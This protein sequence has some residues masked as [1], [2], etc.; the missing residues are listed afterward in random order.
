MCVLTFTLQPAGQPNPLPTQGST[1]PHS[2]TFLHRDESHGPV[3][4]FCSNCCTLL[5][6]TNPHHTHA[7][8]HRHTHT[9]AVKL[10]VTLGTSV[11]SVQCLSSSKQPICTRSSFLIQAQIVLTLNVEKVVALHEPWM[12]TATSL[13][14]QCSMGLSEGL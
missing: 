7:E 14:Q 3:F 9:P 2:D 1:P 12:R 4:H 10:S 11:H 5:G 13:C 8:T 6:C